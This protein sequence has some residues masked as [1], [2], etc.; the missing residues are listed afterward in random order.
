MD[1]AAF[2]AGVIA[3]LPALNFLELK[4]SFPNFLVE[5]LKKHLVQAPSGLNVRRDLVYEL[6]EKGDLV[7][8]PEIVDVF[9]HAHSL[10]YLR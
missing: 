1:S 5:M 10:C 4:L 9:G 8:Q 2:D 3:Q 6:I 7:F